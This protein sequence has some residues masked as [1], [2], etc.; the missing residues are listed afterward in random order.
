MT[1]NVDTIF[2]AGLDV[3]A[4]R[5]AHAVGEELRVRPGDIFLNNL[6]IL[7]G[8]AVDT[9]LLLGQGSVPDATIASTFPQDMRHLTFTAFGHPDEWTFLGYPKN[10]QPLFFANWVSIYQSSTAA[11]DNPP[12]PANDA[13]WTHDAVTVIAKAATYVQGLLKGQAVRDS[14][15]SLGRGNIPAYQGCSGLILFNPEGNTN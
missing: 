3:D 12:P 1:Q 6:R 9:N 2:L 8:D 10:Q 7:C 4:V 11:E 14:L 15:A 5:L 13:F